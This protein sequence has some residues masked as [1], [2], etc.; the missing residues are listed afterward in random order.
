MTRIG[1]DAREF[2]GGHRLTGIGRYLDNLVRPLLTDTSIELIAFSH[3]SAHLPAAWQGIQVVRLPALPRLLVDQVA[4]PRLAIQHGVDVFF[5][6][7]YKIPFTGRF[8]RL[9]T[10]HDVMFLRLPEFPA[11]KRL[12]ASLQLRMAC[13]RA[14]RILVDSAFTG[15]DLGG[16]VP[17]QRHKMTVLY[18][19]LEAAWTIPVDET[20]TAGVRARYAD[21]HPYL[22][23]VGNFKPHKNVNLLVEAFA[24]LCSK[25]SA[26]DHVLVLAGGDPLHRPAIE[27]QIGQLACRDK[28]RIHADLP[29]A[30]LRRLY[31]GARWTVTLSAY[32]GF[33]YPLVEAMACGCPVVYHPCTSLTELVQEGGALGVPDLLQQTVGSVL[34]KAIRMAQ[35]QREALIAIGRRSVTRFMDGSSARQFAALAGEISCN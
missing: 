27:K 22:L 15:D 20:E 18:P 23:Y 34:T 9:I 24:S 8:H 30:D 31:A 14:D 28:I 19:G 29:D 32:E 21:G 7:Y 33:G 17:R 12:L 2:I 16:L 3:N 25:G 13:A 11:W 26:Q 6:P 1:I 10:V 4:L 35:P 5:S